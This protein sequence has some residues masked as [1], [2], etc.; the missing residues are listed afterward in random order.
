METEK[1]LN[2]LR[3]SGQDEDVKLT[4]IAAF[5][6]VSELTQTSHLTLNVF[7]YFIKAFCVLCFRNESLLL[8][9]VVVVV[10]FCFV[11]H[12]FCW[13]AHILNYIF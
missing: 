10:L 6:L 13:N 2:F 11:F 9:F 3:V 12:F 7:S 8:F 4:G 1:L 5:N